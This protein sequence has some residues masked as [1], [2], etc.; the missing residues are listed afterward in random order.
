MNARIQE[1]LAQCE[2]PIFDVFN[3]VQQYVTDNEKFAQLIVKECIELIRQQ[4]VGSERLGGQNF[5]TV[6]LGETIATIEGHFG[7]ET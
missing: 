5:K 2:T 7:V 1:L 4:P 3:V 6:Q